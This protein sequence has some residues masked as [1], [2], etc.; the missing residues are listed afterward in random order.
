MAR[1]RHGI[2]EKNRP[3]QLTET[4][5]IW[6]L[7][8]TGYIGR[9]LVS[10]LA[11]DSGNRLHLLIHRSAPY[12]W[13]EPFN[14]ITGSLSNFDPHWFYRY[15]PDVVFH[16][17]RPAGGHH[18]TRSRAA[19]HGEKANRR[20]ARIVEKLDNPPVV[21]YVS[22]SLLYGPR[23]ANDPASEDS[24]LSPAAFARYYQ[25]NEQPWLEV[26]QSGSLDVRFARPAWIMGPGSWFRKF[27]YEPLL[28]DGKVPYYGDGS[29]LMSLVHLDDCARMID[30]LARYGHPGKNLN[31]FT[32]KPVSQKDF[33][34]M[35]ASL[36]GRETGQL[37]YHQTAKQHG[38]T[39]AQA[40]TTSIP[41]RTMHPEMA[42]KAGIHFQ[43]Q[44]NMI[45]SV[46]QKL[47]H[48]DQTG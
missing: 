36:T 44:K 1:K 24:P 37:T 32:G 3:M 16:L 11:R 42:D 6:V 13:L 10:H 12:R 43:D 4:R 29:Q 46:L 23:P 19:Y 8:G 5:N 27:F 2:K 9:A 26:Q 33:A 22:G 7:G 34:G 31:V 25:R 15:P 18:L 20:L 30:A 35:I 21:V 40:L 38:K 14:A 41:L 47:N 48:G 45:A 39:A 28:R 17:A